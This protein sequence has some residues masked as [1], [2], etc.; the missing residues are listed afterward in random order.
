MVDF[1]NSECSNLAALKKNNKFMCKWCNG[2]DNILWVISME[3][4]AV[5]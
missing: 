4:C 1:F 2:H 3:R 5:E